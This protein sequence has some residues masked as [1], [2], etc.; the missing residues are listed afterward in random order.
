MNNTV[1]A[2]K[3]ILEMMQRNMKTRA[4]AQKLGCEYMV[5]QY[6]HAIHELA[7]AYSI[8]ESEDD[9]N[10]LSVEE[11]IELAKHHKPIYA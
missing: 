9:N 3:A 5:H 4:S 1:T 8:S 7:L 10:P 6:D 11:V 2:A